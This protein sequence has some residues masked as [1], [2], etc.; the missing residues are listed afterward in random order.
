MNDTSDRS[1]RAE[2]AMRVP[3][4]EPGF[5]AEGRGLH[6]VDETVQGTGFA[7][8]QKTPTFGYPEDEEPSRR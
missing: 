2:D 7:A 5:D 4:A 6:Y 8:A 3:G 1:Y